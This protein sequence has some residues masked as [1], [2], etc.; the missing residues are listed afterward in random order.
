MEYSRSK[1]INSLNSSRWNGLVK[2]VTGARR[3][4]KSYLL[5]EL[6]YNFL[7]EEGVPKECI[8]RFAFDMDEDIDKLD[9]FSEGEIIR[10]PNK[11]MGYLI[12][13]KVFRRYIASIIN[14]DK[15]QYYI[16][17]D[18]VQ[19]L[20]NF[21]GTL[22]SYLRHKNM[23][24]YVTGSNSKFL[25]VDIATE[26]KGRSSELHVLPLTFS[27]FVEGVNKDVTKA[28]A[29]YIVYGGIPLVTIMKSED[30]KI[31]YLKN[32]AEE[33][34][35]KDI[36]KRN[37]VR[38]KAEISDTFNVLA[39]LMSRI[40]NPTNISNTFN[41]LGNGEIVPETVERFISFFSDA[42]VL[43]TVKKYNIK[44]RKYIESPFKV[45]FEDIGVRNARLDFR[46]VEESHILENIL[47][48]ELRY[49]GF[50]VSVGEVDI[51]EDTGRKDKNNHSIYANKSLEVDFI[52]IKGSKKYYIQ[53]ALIIP[54]SEKQSQEK[55]SLYYIDDSFKKIVVTKNDLKL[56]RDEKG[57][58]TIDIFDFLLNEDSL[59]Y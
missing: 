40:V 26:F 47:Y 58:V 17:L 23:D 51:S 22:N 45:Y 28:W 24:L 27:E 8:I 34:Y 49:R 15:K 42:F 18:E 55:K 35:L 29:E 10:I 38:K 50:S 19:Y 57:V 32:L 3:S 52:A 16:I 39:S 20:E 43:N 44:G 56:S 36:I 1:Y 9:D 13:A 21:V 12:N 25:S 30:D 6:F 7:V 48:N 4:G 46:Q 37:G 14:D 11:K 33:T 53:S 54:D 59:D 31:Q 41:S 5:N 2:V